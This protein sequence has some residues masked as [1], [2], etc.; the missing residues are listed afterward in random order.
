MLGSSFYIERENYRLHL[1][2]KGVCFEEQ[3]NGT[4]S[5]CKRS[6]VLQEKRINSISKQARSSEQ[7]Y[8]DDFNF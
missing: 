1:K 5:P 3:T 4:G 7:N 6:A 8:K 2:H